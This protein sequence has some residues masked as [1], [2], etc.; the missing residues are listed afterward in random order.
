MLFRSKL[1][2]IFAAGRPTLYVGEPESE[3]GWLLREHNC[4]RALPTA[5]GPS[6]ATAIVESWKDSGGRL[7]QGANA[8]RLAEE[9]SLAN[10]AAAFAKVFRTQLGADR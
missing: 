10:C 2:G 7:V 9:G 1:Y 4:G 3:G 8:R 5:T 6:L